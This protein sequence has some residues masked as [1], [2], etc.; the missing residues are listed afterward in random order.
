MMVNELYTITTQEVTKSSINCSI[1]EIDGDKVLVDVIDDDDS[2]EAFVDE[3]SVEDWRDAATQ[4]LPSMY[5][6][7]PV[8]YFPGRPPDL[9]YRNQDWPNLLGLISVCPNVSGFYKK[10]LFLKH[11][12]FVGVLPSCQNV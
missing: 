11:P 8:L 1:P 2:Q 7:V 9:N 10:W 12:Y 5:P 6:S 4:M 3:F